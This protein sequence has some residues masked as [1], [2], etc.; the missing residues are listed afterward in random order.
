MMQGWM[1]RGGCQGFT[2]HPTI[3]RPTC[4]KGKIR[5]TFSSNTFG[6]GS[7]PGGGGGFQYPPTHPAPT[8]TQGGALNTAHIPA[9]DKWE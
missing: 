2:N 3:H 9:P 4:P 6:A 7:N 1:M 8:P 5:K